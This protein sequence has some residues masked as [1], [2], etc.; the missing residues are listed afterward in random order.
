VSTGDAWPALVRMLAGDQPVLAYVPLR[1]RQW[2]DA[3]P[4]TAALPSWGWLRTAPGDAPAADT[5]FLSRLRQ[6]A[7][8]ARVELAEA[9]IR[10]VAARVLCLKPA[11]VES[12]TP[13]NALGL[14]S[15]TALELRNRLESV[16]DLRL[17]PTLLWTYGNT[18]ALARALCDRLPAAPPTSLTDRA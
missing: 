12:E 14:D 5:S 1:L 4:E 15:L 3:N 10:E 7:G 2:F 13:L 11:E 18:S 6:A 8:P 9:K 17:S 16:F